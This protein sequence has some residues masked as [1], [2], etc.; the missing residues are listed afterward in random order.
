MEV[1]YPFFIAFS[2]IFLAELGD[3]TQMLVISFASKSRIRNIL[4]RCGSWY[5]F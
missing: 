3:K 2:I 4:I 5:L 1:F